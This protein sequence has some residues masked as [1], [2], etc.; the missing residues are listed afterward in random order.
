VGTAVAVI[1]GGVD[2]RRVR[3]IVA[4]HRARQPGVSNHLEIAKFVTRCRSYVVQGR[5]LYAI[6]LGPIETGEGPVHAYVGVGEDG[7]LAMPIVERRDKEG[8][9]A[10]SEAAP[11]GVKLVCE[12]RL[13]RAGAAFGFEPQPMPTEIAR[14]R[15]AMA[16]GMMMGPM[17]APDRQALNVLFEGAVEFLRA[18]P[19]RLWSDED[20]IR[21]ELRGALEATFEGVVMGQGGMEYGL[22]LYARPGAVQ[23]IARA[24]DRHRPDLAAREDAL[25]VTFDVEPRFAVAALREAYGLGKM[26]VPMR[27]TR[28][29]P[30]PL[31]GRD[32]A[33]LGAVLALLGEVT[34]ERRKAAMRIGSG[35]EV[36][37]IQIE[38]PELL[39]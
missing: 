3:T 21:V 1:G 20:V 7:L 11:P 9:R 17:I 15:A 16:V 34:A 26:P 32:L 28:G 8:L 27:L 36:I 12:P 4:G 29:K 13:A 33:I 31:D 10:L 14:T 37:D 30:V 38:A 6:K 22:S 25:A 19:W 24:M 5:V 35:A 39:S 23:R 18:R 2:M